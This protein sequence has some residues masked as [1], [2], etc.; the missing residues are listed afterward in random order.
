MQIP[1]IV[2]DISA[3]SGFSTPNNDLKVL[4]TR[5]G[6]KATLDDA[7]GDITIESKKGQTIAVIHGDGNIRFKAPKNI[8]FAAGEDFIVSAGKNVKIDAKKNVEV[9]AGIDILQNAGNDINI[10]SNGN[11]MEKSDNRTEIVEKDFKRT[12]YTSNEIAAEASLY[13]QQEN[14]TIQSGKQILFNSNEKS[15]LF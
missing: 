9:E 11:I 6:N 3:R 12:S 8:E 10:T 7:T 13:S 5:S 2:V 1:A 14:M 4:A 15:N